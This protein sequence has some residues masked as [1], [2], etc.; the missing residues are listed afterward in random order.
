M[1][2]AHVVS[3]GSLGLG[4]GSVTNEA[5]A[6]VTHDLRN[7][8]NIISVGT[9]LLDDFAQSEEERAEILR[10]IKRATE[11]MDRL[12]ED[13]LTLVRIEGGCVLALKPMRMDIGSLI[14]EVRD[15]FAHPARTE[16]RHLQCRVTE[17]L[18]AVYADPDRVYQVFANLIGNA[19]KFTPKGG[20]VAVDAEMGRHD[21]RC[22]VS[23]TGPGMTK[24]ELERVFDPFWQAEKKARLGF[25]LGLKIAKCIVEAHGGAMQVASTPGTGSCFS[26]TLPLADGRPL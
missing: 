1:D 24:D 20:S 12:I 3:M 10:T 25:G 21:V 14:E 18:P 16:G 23:D 9:S 8:L 17:S 26:F 22:S 11:R 2:D 19:L 13:L 7:P 15:A 5:L 4:T 6:V